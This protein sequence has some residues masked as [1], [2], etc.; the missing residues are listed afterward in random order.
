MTIEV[1]RTPR[2]GDTLL[3][4]LAEEDIKEIRERGTDYMAYLKAGDIQPLIVTEVDP[5]DTH[6]TG[7]QV[8][9]SGTISLWRPSLAEDPSGQTPR[10]YHY[11]D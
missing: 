9:I 1:K 8:L 4:V 3:Y 2:I 11:R 7:G 10:S 6:G 5:K